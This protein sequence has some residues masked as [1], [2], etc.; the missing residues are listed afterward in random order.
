MAHHW[1]RHCP[2]GR[3]DWAALLVF[4]SIL[5][6]IFIPVFLGKFYQLALRTHSARGTVFDRVFGKT[7]NIDEYF[8][9]FGTLIILKFIFDYFYKYF[10]GISGERF[11]KSLREQL[12]SKQLNTRLDVHNKKD[13]GMYL[14]RYSG[15]LSCIHGYLTKG[16]ISFTKDCIFLTLAIGLL[17]LINI[18]LALIVIILFPII[19]F[20]VILI[21]KNLKEYTVKRRNIRA[22]NLAFISSRLHSLLTVKIFNR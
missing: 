8:L 7:T 4:L 5:S 22:Q 13:T 11:S 1:A 3:P 2:A 18:P 21:N 15:D 9:L 16:I 14:L 19:F 17:L 6:T 10:S 12:F 20:I